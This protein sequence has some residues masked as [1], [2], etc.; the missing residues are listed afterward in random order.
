MGA[1]AEKSTAEGEISRESIWKECSEETKSGRQVRNEK[2][3]FKDTKPEVNTKD[4]QGLH[5]Y[6]THDSYVYFRNLIRLFKTS[7]K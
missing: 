7:M 6:S 4:C 2:G 1:G 3:I 5:I